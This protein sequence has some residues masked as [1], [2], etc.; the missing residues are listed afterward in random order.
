MYIQQLKESDTKLIALEIHVKVRLKF[1]INC[2]ED[3]VHVVAF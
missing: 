2:S 1:L 3:F